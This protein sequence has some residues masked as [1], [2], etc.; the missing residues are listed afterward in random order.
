MKKTIGNKTIIA[1]AKVT[2]S[3]AV[4]SYEHC[5]DL[6]YLEYDK[7]AKK[8]VKRSISVTFADDKY[9]EWTARFKKLDEKGFVGSYVMVKF[10]LTEDGKANG[11]DF[12]L[13]GRKSGLKYE[14]DGEEKYVVVLFG[15]AKVRDDA[16]FATVNGNTGFSVTVPIDIFK[17]GK[18]NTEWIKVTF[19]NGVDSNGKEN[20]LA[21]RAEKAIKDGDL[22]AINTGSIKSVTDKEKDRVYFNATGFGFDIISRKKKDEASDSETAEEETS[23]ATTYDENIDDDD[24]DE[25]PIF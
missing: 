19:W 22:I 2:A 1:G 23:L 12:F 17:N 13:P 15:R 20:A 5:L 6:S 10:V 16:K 3:R 7:N 24:D 8:E 9:N 4:S 14:K 11:I 18:E 21:D 25:E